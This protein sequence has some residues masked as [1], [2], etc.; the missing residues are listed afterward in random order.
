MNEKIDPCPC[1][2]GLEYNPCCGQFLQ[3]KRA[4]TAEQL[5]RSRYTAYVVNDETYLLKTWHKNTRPQTLN[6][7]Q[8]PPLKWM[9][10]K[11]LNH[12]VDVEYP[13][14]ARVEFVARYK[15][16]GKAEKIHELSRF[17]KQHGRW[18]YVDG[19]F[20]PHIA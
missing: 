6:L 14:Q 20:S 5:M 13:D 18:F 19:D 1:G 15:V 8:Q 17:K 10:L 7:S 3:G 16:N 11:V 4:N 9:G 2:S 12:I